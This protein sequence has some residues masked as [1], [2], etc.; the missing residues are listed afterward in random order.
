MKYPLTDIHLMNYIIFGI[1]ENKT[2][3]VYE[4]V[5][6][7]MDCDK[8]C[9]YVYLV[10]LDYYKAEKK[11]IVNPTKFQSWHSGPCDTRLHSELEINNGSYGAID[12]TPMTYDP[13][14]FDEVN[15]ELLDNILYHLDRLS[16]WEMS[17]RIMK[18]HPSSA[19]YKTIAKGKDSAFEPLDVND[20]IQE[21]EDRGLVY[22]SREE[23]REIEEKIEEDRQEFIKDKKELS[24]DEFY[25]K[26]FSDRIMSLDEDDPNKFIESYKKVIKASGCDQYSEDQIDLIARF[27][28]L[29]EMI[30]F[31]IVTE[32]VVNTKDK[33]KKLFE[34]D[35]FKD[36]DK[37]KLIDRFTER[38]I[39]MT[40]KY[41]YYLHAKYTFKRKD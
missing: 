17:E 15:I 37:T 36:I 1:K 31:L 5:V 8:L 32:C 22:K 30:N 41:A 35:L 29:D 12:F 25:E 7:Y 11:F 21:A 28:Y 39:N 14:S 4:P 6:R 24:P 27:E 13:F 18:Y 38:I 33:I 10:L 40:E 19:L 3:E 20:I 16:S 9:R 2:T 23:E 34:S 26:Y